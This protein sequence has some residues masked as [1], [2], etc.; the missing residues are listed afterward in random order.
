MKI[1]TDSLCTA[2]ERNSVP[3]CG[4]RSTS[5]ECY[6]DF[7]SLDHAYW[8]LKSYAQYTPPTRRNCRVASRRRC[9]HEFATSWRQFCRVGVHTPVGSRE[10]GNGRRLRCAFTLP[11]PTRRNKTVSSRRRRRCVLGFRYG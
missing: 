11:T 8:N 7:Q 3:L 6:T 2:R 9:V 1:Q 5:T 10:L 4:R